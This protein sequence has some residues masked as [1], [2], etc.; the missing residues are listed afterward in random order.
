[1]VLGVLTTPDD[2][3]LQRLEFPDTSQAPNPATATETVPAHPKHVEDPLFPAPDTPVHPAFATFGHMTV[4]FI[5]P[6]ANTTPVLSGETNVKE[7]SSTVP[8]EI[9][10]LPVQP[11]EVA[12]RLSECVMA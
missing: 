1:M 11:F 4:A 10:A 6:E 7:P 5:C 2:E 12:T 8:F 3:Q 9:F